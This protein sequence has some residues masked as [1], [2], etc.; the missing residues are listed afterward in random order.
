ML[1]LV[2]LEEMCQVSLHPIVRMRKLRHEYLTTQHRHKEVGLFGPQPAVR[3]Q[4]R[5]E[6]EE[7][8]AGDFRT[9]LPNR[10]SGQDGKIYSV[11]GTTVLPRVGT[12]S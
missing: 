4:V 7:E 11:P 3:M 12:P 10:K 1:F 2:A 8:G 9:Y 6:K 5:I